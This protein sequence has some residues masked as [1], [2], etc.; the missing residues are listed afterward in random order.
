MIAVPT[1]YRDA[2]R[3]CVFLYHTLVAVRPGKIRDTHFTEDWVNY[4]SS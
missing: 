4:A 1:Q 3:V 2:R